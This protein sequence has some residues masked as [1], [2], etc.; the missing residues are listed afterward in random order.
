MVV[1]ALV[2]LAAALVLLFQVYAV[3]GSLP[4]LMKAEL[5]MLG[6]GTNLSQF[7]PL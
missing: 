7:E 6:L 1:P 2:I 4:D 5:F 3:R